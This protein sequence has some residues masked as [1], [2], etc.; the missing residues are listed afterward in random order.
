MATRRKPI[1]KTQYEIATGKAKKVNRGNQVKR[2]DK[3]TNFYL[4]L[5]FQRVLTLF[6]CN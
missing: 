4:G 5:Y 1:P 6:N 2:D 3:T